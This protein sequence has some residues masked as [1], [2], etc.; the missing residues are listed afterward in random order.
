M[1]CH[2]V[3]YKVLVHI[4]RWMGFT[5]I[6]SA[7]IA[8]EPAA[9]DPAAVA[10]VALVVERAG[11]QA[12]TEP[13]D[14]NR[15]ARLQKTTKD[16]LCI[17]HGISL[18]NEYSSLPGNTWGSPSFRDDPELADTPLSEIGKA[19]TRIELPEQLLHETDL[20]SF[21]VGSSL[22]G[23]QDDGVEL[24]LVSPLTR[25]LQTYEY[26]VKP[27]LSKLLTG[28]ERPLHHS[29][30]EHYKRTGL[31][32]PVLALPLLSSRVYTISDT[33]RPIAVLEEEF[34][35]I[36]FS[37]CYKPDSSG[38]TNDDDPWWYT[39]VSDTNTGRDQEWR[40]HGQ[41]QWYAVPGEPKDVFDRRMEELKAW[42]F[43]RKETKILLVTHWGVLRYLSKGTEWKN[44]EAKIIQLR[45]PS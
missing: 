25:C 33:G 16:L 26:G 34:P 1:F 32:I 9:E 28:G 43:R 42:L 44:A 11:D 39:G 10:S 2:I 19:R 17:R 20:R 30:G 36:D 40:P 37:E 5:S 45:P 13:I 18:F 6:G 31:P 4:L 7:N 29:T 38:Q 12:P 15:E 14:G 8:D 21:L 24:V 27:V 23:V 22:R 41:G 35:D 3:A